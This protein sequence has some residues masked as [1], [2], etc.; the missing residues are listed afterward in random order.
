MACLQGTGAQ[1]HRG[2]GVPAGHREGVGECC[3]G[4]FAITI[5][6]SALGS[7]PGCP[8]PA[9]VAGLRACPMV[10][11]GRMGSLY[12]PMVRDGPMGSL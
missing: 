2:H 1:E 5:F 10:R 6:A 3:T 4:G 11:D 8:W 9:R 12:G 7:A